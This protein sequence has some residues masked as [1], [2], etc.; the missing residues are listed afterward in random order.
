[1][2]AAACNVSQ[3]S[4]LLMYENQGES[5]GGQHVF[6]MSVAWKCAV[7]L[8]NA[9]FKTSKAKG[10]ALD[11]LDSATGVVVVVVMMMMMMVMMVVVVV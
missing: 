3:G 1:M 6:F 8:V 9:R 2:L 4:Q 11:R 5:F 7:S 10:N